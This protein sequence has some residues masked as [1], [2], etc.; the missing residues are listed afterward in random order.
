M[1]D[2]NGTRTATT[3]ALTLV[4][5]ASLGPATT[6]YQRMRAYHMAPQAVRCPKC[7]AGFATYCQSTGGGYGGSVP[8]HKVRQD[9]I[10]AWSDDQRHKYGDLARRYMRAPWEA[11]A[12]QVAEAE[13]AAAPIVVK[14]APKVT[15]KGVRLS[16]LQAERIEWAA[17]AGG[18]TSASTAHFHGDHQERQTVLSLVAKGILAEGALGSRGYD[19]QYTLTEFGW[20]VYFQHRLII[21]HISD[22]QAKAFMAAAGFGAVAVAA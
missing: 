1:A 19:R 7:K 15:P 11:P 21:R 4:H 5:T 13:A 6:D 9:R 10:A 3:P 8:T 18:E 20:Q 12:D 17:A 14:S 22:E 16:E 2:H